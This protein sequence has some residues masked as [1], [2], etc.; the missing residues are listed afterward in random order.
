[1]VDDALLM[2]LSQRI[3]QWTG[4]DV[5]ARLGDIRRWL[6]T[7]V[8]EGD[9]SSLLALLKRLQDREQAVT[10]A[11]IQSLLISHTVFFRDAEQLQVVSAVLTERPYDK[12]R[13][14]VAGC[15]SGEEAYTVALIVSSHARSAEIVATDIS[16]AALALAREGR[17]SR[18]CLQRIPAVHHREFVTTD[19]YIHASARLRRSIRFVE[20]NLLHAPLT[21][22]DA[23]GWD[24][25]LCRNVLVHFQADHAAATLQRLSSAL[26][27]GGLLLLG[28]GEFHHRTPL[29]SPVEIAGR[30]LLARAVEAQTARVSQSMAVPANQPQPAVATPAASATAI[31]RSSTESLVK[32]KHLAV[33]LATGSLD[34]VLTDTLSTLR[35]NPDH[36][37]AL[38]LAGI[39]YHQKSR[40]HE[41]TALL[42]RS[43]AQHPSCWPA[44]HFLAL[45]LDALGQ[46]GAALSA[47]R[48]VKESLQPTPAAQ[49]LI[50]LLDFGPWRS[51]AVALARLRLG[52]QPGP[53]SNGR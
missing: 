45:S 49:A 31:H 41:A 18:D 29:L 12:L 9:T 11:L 53:T 23:Q 8:P 51:E 40:H 22:S 20:H 7:Q 21:P 34:V 30:I 39:A 26:V 37:P 35:A 33:L 13:I 3:S 16:A 27:P 48:C 10:A 42:E 15:S 52:E 4:L 14:W 6:Q 50:D 47:F 2:P 1:M 43:L 44:A 32:G 38:L 25:I 19:G 36:Q 46:K 17:Y 5:G 28:A 24:L